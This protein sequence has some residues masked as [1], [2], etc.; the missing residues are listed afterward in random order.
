MAYNKNNYDK[1]RLTP[2]QEKF[3]D[4][5]LEGKTQYQAY[6]EAYPNA[7]TYKRKSVDELASSLMRNTKI[8]SR[9]EQLGYRDKTKVMW[10]RQRA[11]EE[12]NYML[13]VNRKDIERREQ[14]YEQMKAQK[15]KDLQD[16]IQLKGVPNIDEK[17]VQQQ[18][19]RLIKEI[20]NIELKRRADAVNNNGIVNAAKTLNRMFGFDITK[21]EVNTIDEEREEMDKLT[22]DELKELINISKK[23]N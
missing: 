7:Q 23:E 3:V 6:L 8:K 22:A 2:K 15:F 20:Q 16:W 18:I 14:T 21:V 17:G 10:T 13:E 5:I 19:D 11:L 1:Q 9:L 4:G 12:I